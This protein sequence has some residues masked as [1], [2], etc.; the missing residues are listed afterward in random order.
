VKDP[1]VIPDK[2]HAYLPEG[3]TVV[4]YGNLAPDGAVIKQSAVAEN[5]RVFTGPA[6]VF[7]AESDALEA[8]REKTLREGE[9]IVIR[10]EGPK[11]GPGMPE[12]LA[13]TMGLDL[14]GFTNV[15]L[16]T[17]GRFSGAT[18][19]PCI[20]HVAP[21]AACGGTIALVHDGD[22]I[23]IDISAHSLDVQVSQEELE[24]RR[25]AWKPAQREIP[26]GFMRR[27]VKMVGSA[28]NGAILE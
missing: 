9:V 19:G 8:I 20:G 1:A 4:L 15:A 16:V 6:R 12:T 11:G 23:T 13:V 21:E 10:Y 14:A 27:Y 28:A 22:L 25:A 26:A 2:T 18:A 7:D 5:M 17:D 24:Q 3:G